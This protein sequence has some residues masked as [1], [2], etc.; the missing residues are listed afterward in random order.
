MAVCSDI[1]LAGGASSSSALVV[2]SDIAVRLAG[3]PQELD[4]RFKME[5]AMHTPWGEWFVGTRGGSMDQITIA[6]GEPGKALSMSFGPFRVEKI[7]IPAKGYRWV[8][9]YTHPHGGGSQIETGYNERSAASLYV[10]K[11]SIEKTLENKPRLK[12]KWRRIRKA[13]EEE[14]ARALE[15]LTPDM[16]KILALLPEYLTLKQIR[17][18]IPADIY[19]E[20]VTRYGS[21]FRLPMQK[22]IT[23]KRWARHHFEEVKGSLATVK[24]LKEAHEA[25]RRGDL[26]ALSEKMKKVGEKITESGK[27]LRDLYGLSTPD[28]DRVMEVALATEGV[29]G[30]YIHGGG[31]GGSA[32]VLV[33]K[34][35]VERLIENETERYYRRRRRGHKEPTRDDFIMADPG[36]GL[37]LVDF[38]C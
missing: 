21:L 22:R 16:E 10:I 1:P 36:E 33:E 25:E 11:E 28:L 3:G 37:S 29:L 20:M 15:R 4:S 35:S 19:E 26:S 18:L 9:V 24:L 32:L 27:R 7:R 30:A 2:A 6:L 17:E 31:F 34:D 13:A 8:T 38:P 23:V 5:A 14:D 12:E